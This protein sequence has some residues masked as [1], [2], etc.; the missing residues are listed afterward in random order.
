MDEKLKSTLHKIKLLSE[1]NPE[2]AQELRKMFESSSS[3][4]VVSAPMTIANDIVCIREALEIRAG[5][6]I[7]YEFVTH[8]RFRNQLII[9][10][11]RMENAALDL[12]KSEKDRFYAFCVNAFYQLEN[13]TNYFF[14]ITYPNL[15]NLLQVIETYTESEK[16]DY[17][18]CRS[19]KEE[20]VSS[21]SSNH[22]LNAFCNLYFPGDNIKLTLGTLRKVRN[23]GEHLWSKIID[24]N[25]ANH[26]IYKFY[27]YQ[28]FNSIRLLLKRVVTAVEDN[29]GKPVSVGPIYEDA[30]IT[31]ILPSACFVNHNGKTENLPNSCLNK[32]KGCTAEQ[33]IKLVMTGPK[34]IDVIVS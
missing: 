29:L 30:I 10:N 12:R 1:Q 7:D 8:V 16:E 21:I 31:S 18:F 22:K 32:I 27:K 25:E 19:G 20:N 9:D 5:N 13:I 15:N 4:S 2:F 17:R 23:E 14:H 11:L 26:H 28:T 6:S 3:A 33:K 24:N 34:I